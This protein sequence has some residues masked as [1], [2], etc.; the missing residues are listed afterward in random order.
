MGITARP[1]RTLLP[2]GAGAP[3]REPTP[4]PLGINPNVPWEPRQAERNYTAHRLYTRFIEWVM[5]SPTWQGIGAAIIGAYARALVHDDGVPGRDSPDEPG[6]WRFAAVGDYGAGTVHEARVAETIRRGAPQLVI[7]VGDNVYPTGKWEDYQK[8]F[9]PP[10]Y[11]GSLIHEFPFMPSIGNHD[12]IYRNDLRP[13]FAHFQHL[14]GHPYYAFTF[15][16][17]HFIALD[18]DQDLRP[19]SE[20]RRWLERELASST[21]TFRVV[22]MHYPMYSDEVGDFEEIRG[23]LQPLLTRYRVQLMVTGHVHNYQ[24]TR[25]IDGTVHIIT[26]NG[27]Q[28]VFASRKRRGPHTAYRKAVYGHVEV[29]VG[30]T[31][32]VVRAFDEHGHLIDA[33]NIPATGADDAH[34]GA[35]LLRGR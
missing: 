28:Q 31:R 13:Y 33:T 25:P 15:R 2:Q 21:S 20:Q 1:T 12:E 27:G 16:N 19:G 26:G 17:A 8:N 11:Y 10:E 5:E 6:S 18:G 35:S 23:S 9:D 29:S 34:A 32:M 22:Y 7:T 3:N 4:R 24:R 14:D 30:P